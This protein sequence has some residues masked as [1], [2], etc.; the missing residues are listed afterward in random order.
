MDK[1]WVF[2]YKSIAKGTD[3][4]LYGAGKIGAS[5]KEQIDATGYCNIVAW[6]DSNYGKI[7]GDFPIQSPEVVSHSAY[8]YILV[9]IKSYEDTEEIVKWLKKKNID[10]TKIITINECCVDNVYFEIRE[11]NFDLEPDLKHLDIAFVVPNPIKGGGG[12]RNIFR[13]IRYLQDFGHKITVYIFHPSG[14]ADQVKKEVS[15][16]FY[17]MNGVTFVCNNGELG[18]HDAGVAT[19]WETVYVFRNQEDHFRNIFYFVQDFEPYF[20]ALSSGYYLAENTYKLG[21]SHICSGPWI[22][23]VLREKYAAESRYFQFP[24]DTKIYNTGYKRVKRNTNIIFFA[25][26]EMARR[27]FELGIEALKIFKEN[28]SEIEI[29]L[30]GSTVLEPKMVPFE[31][32]ILNYVPTLQG[33]AELYANADLGIVFSPT[34]P[35]LVPYEMM[36]CGCPVVDLDVD[37]AITKYGNDENNVFLLDPLPEKFSASLEEILKNKELLKKHRDNGLEWVNSEFPSEYEMAK[38]V[39]ECIVKKIATGSIY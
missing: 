7:N 33:L 8:D 31:A 35:S 22:D 16:W 9:A 28:N 38:I 27:C 39:E 15:E 24:L 21:Y 13:A 6:V 2:P 37:L 32:T 29:V 17:P 5:F 14:G 10:P 34:N 30:F 11:K 26:P 19:S 20:S 25:K 12:H 4:I 36:S 1:G 23:R 3:I 18:Y